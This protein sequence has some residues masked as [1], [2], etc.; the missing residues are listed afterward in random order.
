M[1]LYY[2]LNVFSMPFPPLRQRPGD[3]PLL[4]AHFVQQFANRLSKNISQFT[5]GAMGALIR[6]PWPGNI[7]K[8]LNYIRRTW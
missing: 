6:Y 7:R 8:C 2:R 3:I 5:Q 1:D 4:V